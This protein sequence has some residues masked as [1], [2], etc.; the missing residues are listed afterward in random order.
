MHA[1]VVRG[2]VRDSSAHSS[3]LP[4]AGPGVRNP[5]AAGPAGP[6]P[7]PRGLPGVKLRAISP[8]W[9]QTISSIG[10]FLRFRISMGHGATPVFFA[11]RPYLIYVRTTIS[12]YGPYNWT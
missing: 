10:R 1:R 7:S 4:L 6:F 3:T 12:Y 9:K 11:P 5:V 8:A 2:C